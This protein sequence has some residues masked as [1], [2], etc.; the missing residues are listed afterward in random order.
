MKP[1]K[2]LQYPKRSFLER[3]L[4]PKSEKPSLARVHAFSVV[5]RAVAFLTAGASG[6]MVVKFALTAA[7]RHMPVQD[8]VLT[9]LGIATA[10]VLACSYL[11]TATYIL[12]LHLTDYVI[13]FHEADLLCPFD[14]YDAIYNMVRTSAFRLNSDGLLV[15]V[16]AWVVP[17]TL[18]VL[19]ILLTLFDK[20]YDS[21]IRLLTR[22]FN[23]GRACG[24]QPPHDSVHLSRA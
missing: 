22:G 5:A 23:D 8:L 3:T 13:R 15:S 2:N 10:V 18:A 1:E 21:P 6:A 16:L 17:A 14:P 7:F 19:A 24:Y 4:F 9:D 12:T 20:G 11:A